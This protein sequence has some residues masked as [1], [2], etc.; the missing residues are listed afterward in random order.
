MSQTTLDEYG[1]KLLSSWEEVYKKGQLTLWIMI[2]LKDGPKHMG[3]I[4]AFIQE[5]TNG[6]LEADNQSMYRALRRY[7]DAELLDA[8]SKPGKSGA[9][10]KVYQLS[11]LGEQ[12]LDSFVRRNITQVFYQPHIKQLF[13]RS[14]K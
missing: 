4:K 2:A 13:E 1:T 11:K 10:R 12:V 8:A 7:Y 3:A 14:S 5:A 6:T 9:D